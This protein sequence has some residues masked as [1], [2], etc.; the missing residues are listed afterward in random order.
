MIWRHRLF[1]LRFPVCAGGGHFLAEM[2]SEWRDSSALL[3]PNSSEYQFFLYRHIIF[4]MYDQGYGRG[5]TPVFTRVF[6]PVARVTL[7]L[8]DENGLGTCFGAP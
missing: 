8:T 6:E 2:L 4:C 3:N 1:G 5:V 7:Y